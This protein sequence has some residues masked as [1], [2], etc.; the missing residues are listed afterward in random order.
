[1]AATAIKRLQTAYSSINTDVL[2]E[3]KAKARKDL[4]T[5]AQ[6][7]ERNI[8]GD[9]AVS[10]VLQQ[11]S[12]ILAERD[13]T[14]KNTLFK[15]MI[16][17]G[18]LQRLLEAEQDVGESEESFISKKRIA[19]KLLEIVQG[20]IQC[21]DIIEQIQLF[22]RRAIDIH[23]PTPLALLHGWL[24]AKKGNND[25]LN[26]L[27]YV[28]DSIQG[29]LA[30]AFSIAKDHYT[31]AKL[32]E[33]ISSLPPP[34]ISDSDSL[35]LATDVS[36][37]KKLKKQIS[38]R[39]KKRE[40]ASGSTL[41]KDWVTKKSSHYL[42][43][44]NS[45]FFEFDEYA[46]PTLS[47]DGIDEVTGL[48]D[49]IINNPDMNRNLSEEQLV[50]F[51]LYFGIDLFKEAY[52]RYGLKGDASI[53]SP[54]DYDNLRAIVIGI[55]STYSVDDLKR[56]PLRASE[57]LNK[58]LKASVDQNQEDATIRLLKKFDQRKQNTI[59]IH[60]LPWYK[61]LGVYL[62]AVADRL[63]S[64]V[65]RKTSEYYIGSIVP[66]AGE[67]GTSAIFSVT[68]PINPANTN[69]L[70]DITFLRAQ[71]HA[72]RFSRAPGG[73]F[74]TPEQLE[75]EILLSLKRKTT[76]DDFYE[77]Y[78]VF[79][80]KEYAADKE[81][82]QSYFEN[83]RMPKDAA[84][85]E[86]EEMAKNI[87]K[88][89]LKQLREAGRAEYM[90]HNLA[91][92]DQYKR[93]GHILCLPDRDG[94]MRDFEVEGVVRDENGLG[95]GFY[96]PVKGT[97]IESDTIPLIINAPGTHNA[98]SAIR[99]L[100]P[101]SAGYD[102]FSA[103]NKHKYRER[104]IKQL[105]SKIA[106]LKRRYPG[107]KVAIEIF[108]HS[109]GGG[110]SYNLDLMIMEAMAQNK[111][112]SPVGGSHRAEITGMFSEAKNE[113]LRGA[114]P[115]AL[116]ESL[117]EE[118][119]EVGF[120][121]SDNRSYNPRNIYN[122]STDNVAL[123]SRCSDRGAGMC[124]EVSDARLA[125]SAFLAHKSDFRKEDMNL[126]IKGDLLKYTGKK[127]GLVDADPDEAFITDNIQ[128]MYVETDA[129]TDTKDLAWALINDGAIAPLEAHVL[130]QALSLEH[131]VRNPH[132]ILNNSNKAEYEQ[133]KNKMTN[134]VK[135]PFTNTSVAE[136]TAYRAVKFAFY[137]AAWGLHKLVDLIA[138]PFRFIRK[139]LNDLLKPA[140]YSGNIDQESLDSNSAL[141]KEDMERKIS[142][143]YSPA[144]RQESLRS[145]SP[146]GPERPEA[147][148]GPKGVDP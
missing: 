14:K 135:V 26:M 16:I 117:G 53:Q 109:L 110:D 78:P 79:A 72:R 15:E 136:L 67:V 50:M 93:D 29:N 138:T 19:E 12:S 18:S 95:V 104:I 13:L 42:E 87:I 43:N 23:D 6:L 127:Q 144:R 3:Y 85:I 146:T 57:S 121:Y 51:S 130:T 115:K 77:S 32:E 55:A 36:S 58:V 44:K 108:G 74:K 35:A 96:T 101:I 45:I 33:D 103:A 114:L 48:I 27:A 56:M 70:N 68:T 4:N 128:A 148:A 90:A 105:N 20:H 124:Q 137:N 1:M 126:H 62:G 24:E 141:E 8:S 134:N 147:T 5:I 38:T 10:E 113:R 64:F 22:K 118:N 82:L 71:S 2:R 94:K 30:K 31:I 139:Q 61:Q 86:R 69:F 17:E 63:A 119:R 91:Y 83:R 65:L 145:D 34:P 37:L 92:K 39:F 28:P 41:S 84:F 73:T 125:L 49:L 116:A 9:M 59:P 60:S 142:L 99:D 107:K 40:R 140:K 102:E 47:Q 100:H 143:L 52:D 46:I 11:V 132:L 131:S 7:A 98:E 75:E 80:Q 81:V 106:E 133:L 97:Y 112:R 120:G 111:M 129:D 76:I 88:R 123:V 54:F 25:I 66:G 89:R 122:I 21:T